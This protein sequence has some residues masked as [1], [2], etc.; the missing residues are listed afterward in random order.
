MT[1]KMLRSDS[2]HIPEN[3]RIK[4]REQIRCELLTNQGEVYFYDTRRFGTFT[5]VFDYNAFFQKKDIA[6]DSLN[7]EK[8]AWPIF[9]KALQK[10][11]RPIKAVLLDQSSI[12]GVGNI[13]ADEALHLQKIHPSRKANKINEKVAKD[14]FRRIRKIFSFSIRSGGTT[15]NNYLSAEGKKGKY[16]EKLFVYGRQGEACHSCNTGK[17]KMIRLAGRSTHFCPSCQAK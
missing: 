15:V 7:E 12:A 9:W 5:A 3:I 14:L 11:S 6:P 4:K 13:Y 16:V 10:S 17:I 8:E 2:P 1:G